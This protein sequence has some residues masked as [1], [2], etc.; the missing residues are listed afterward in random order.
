ML[1]TVSIMCRER[2]GLC[3][4]LPSISAKS[5]DHPRSICESSM[6][7]PKHLAGHDGRKRTGEVADDFHCARR[8]VLVDQPVGDVL[9][10]L[11]ESRDPAGRE[12]ARTK[13]RSRVCV[14][15]S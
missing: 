9:D 6:G 10:M 8:K 2:S 12:G 15:P 13:L 1:L 4:K 5:A 11:P 7:H 14:V 3:W